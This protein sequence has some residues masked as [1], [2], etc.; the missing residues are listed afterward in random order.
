MARPRIAVGRKRRAS[1]SE[2]HENRV[3]KS[4]FVISTLITANLISAL[5]LA[6]HHTNQVPAAWYAG[7]L[8]LFMLV[9]LGLGTIVLPYPPRSYGFDFSEW[10]ADLAESLV[11][12]ALLVALAIVVR[13]QLVRAGFTLFAYRPPEGWLETVIS[14]P[15][16]LF[17][18][19]IQEAVT[20]GYFQSYFVAIFEKGPAN[21]V[22][23][24]T[25]SSV[26]FAQFHLMYG[27]PVFALSFLLSLF[28]GWLYERRRSILGVTVIHATLG[29]GM[30]FFSYF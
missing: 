9:M 26:V 2:I 19:L 6:L 20:R 30:L 17:A 8:Y 11:I 29:M 16:Y 1:S 4:R 15:V 23:A 25:L 27:L 28:L 18:A 10:R 7:I 14:V 13:I 12:S 3:K 22:L 21:K 24:I 5:G